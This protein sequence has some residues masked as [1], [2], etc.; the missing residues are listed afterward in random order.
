MLSY[1]QASARREDK[2]SSWL[3]SQFHQACAS[4]LKKPSS[5]RGPFVIDEEEL[6]AM[7]SDAREEKRCRILTARDSD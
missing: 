4:L 5:R 1:D 7:H 3:Y 6:I 2:D